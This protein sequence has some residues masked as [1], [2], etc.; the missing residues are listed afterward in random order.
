MINID[1]GIDI[2]ASEL[3]LYRCFYSICNNLISF[4]YEKHF[5]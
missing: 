1:I 5:Q 2:R 3:W 4:V